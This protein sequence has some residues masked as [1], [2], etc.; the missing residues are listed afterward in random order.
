MGYIKEL[1]SNYYDKKPKKD[2][3]HKMVSP[4]MLGGCP[5]VAWFKA[6][7]IPE[8]TPPDVHA[9]M[10]FEVGNLWE[11]KMSEYLDVEGKLIYWWNEGQSPRMQV[12]PTKWNATLRTDAWVDEELNL[13]GTPDQFIEE[14]GNYCLLDTKTMKDDAAKYI[15]HLSNEEYFAT[16]GYGYKLQLGAYLILNKRRYEAGLEEHL[17]RYGK[18]VIISKDNGHIIKEPVLFLTPE[19]EQEVL[20]K[21]AYIDS[22]I[23]SVTPPPC[24]CEGWMVEYCNY[25]DISSMAPNKKKKVVPTRCC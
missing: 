16:K 11:A 25:G 5:R 13:R 8:T 23:K 22:C 17:A 3:T 10:N 18:L 7:G 1:V 19:L 9:Q 24:T 2:M 14:N 4:S 20:D 12:D 15:A 6:N 21:V